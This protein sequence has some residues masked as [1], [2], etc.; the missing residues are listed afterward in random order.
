M[1]QK[2]LYLLQ[3][4]SIYVAKL[5]A[6][7][8]KVHAE[9]DDRALGAEHSSG[10]GFAQASPF[11]RISNSGHKVQTGPLILRRLFDLINHQNVDLRLG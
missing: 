6:R 2:E 11:Q 1:T 8:P 5:C 3:F 7:A 9:R 4:T 10:P